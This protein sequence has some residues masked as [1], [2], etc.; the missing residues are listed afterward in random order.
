MK[1]EALAADLKRNGVRR[2]YAF[3]GPEGYFRDRGWRLVR[4]ALLLS[5]PRSDCQTLD[6]GEKPGDS[7]RLDF[8][9]LLSD[10]STPALFGGRTA[11]RVRHAETV[12]KSH[13]DRLLSFIASAR[14]SWVL[15]LDMEKLDGR[16]KV[17]KKLEEQG[18]VVS[19]ETPWASPPPWSK[20]PPHENDLARW[21]AGEFAQRGKKVR[22]ED[23]HLLCQRVGANLF[24][25]EQE[26]E[27][28]AGYAGKGAVGAE[29]IRLL[30]G[31]SRKEKLFELADSVYG[32]RPAEALF[33]LSRVFEE[34]IEDASGRLTTNPAGI[35]LQAAGALASEL[36]RIRAAREAA[37]REKLGEKELAEKIGVRPFVAARLLA[38][39]RR[40]SGDRIASMV[41]ELDRAD[42]DLKGSGLPP[43]WVLE[44]SVVRIASG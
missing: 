16:T 15:V 42:R 29:A 38:H 44:R 8:P 37:S 13:G 28:L 36:R 1:F 41:R 19:C 22:L 20:D 10:L 30:V 5:D 23:A 27:K 25:L 18:A 2:A 21:V 12:L 32:G 26:I 9:R 6:A 34:G 11:I 33:R 39:A 4:D 7:G 35:A 43:Q 40:L 17:A 3:A 24:A 31:A 14:G